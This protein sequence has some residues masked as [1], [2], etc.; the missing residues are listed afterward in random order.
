[1]YDTLISFSSTL[2]HYISLNYRD[3][4]LYLKSK[5]LHEDKVLK[6]KISLLQ[7]I[8]EFIHVFQGEEDCLFLHI[9][10]MGFDHITASVDINIQNINVE[11][12]ELYTKRSDILKKE[13]PKPLRTLEIERIIRDHYLLLLRK[14]VGLT[15]ELTPAEYNALLN[16]EIQTEVTDPQ[17][18]ISLAIASYTESDG[19]GAIYYFRKALDCKEMPSNIRVFI[20]K[21][22]SRLL[23]PDI[24]EGGIGLI[25]LEIKEKSI[26][27][28]RL[29]IGDVIYK[30][31]GNILLEPSDVSS[32]MA[33]TRKDESLLIEVYTKEQKS[34][35]ISLPGRTHLE[36][37]VSQSVMLNSFFI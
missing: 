28:D 6:S 17:K 7:S 22:L 32:I 16:K 19:R 20:E 27:S 23:H 11:L 15:E 35:S 29:N 36:C 8:R 3:Y 2:S 5:S 37:V 33:K 26:L 21:S 10:E 25:V 30:I 12:K 14:S 34:I 31:N 9:S 13:I 4:E 1:M 24:Y 18:L